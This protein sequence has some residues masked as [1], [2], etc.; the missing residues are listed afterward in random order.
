MNFCPAILLLTYE[1]PG[2][3]P[4]SM[5][6]RRSI[7]GRRAIRCPGASRQAVVIE[8]GANITYKR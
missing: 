2:F 5:S 7:F 4:G 3:V 8:N 1:I 6:L